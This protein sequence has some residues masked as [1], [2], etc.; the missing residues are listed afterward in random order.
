M[1][2]AKKL[3]FRISL[4]MSRSKKGKSLAVNLTACSLCCCS[5]SSTPARLGQA[6][7]CICGVR[8][9][10]VGF[11]R[12]SGAILLAQLAGNH[13][14]R[15][16]APLH[17]STTLCR[18]LGWRSVTR[19]FTGPLGALFLLRAALSHDVCKSSERMGRNQ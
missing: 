15:E 16:D 18:H 6:S 3:P 5:S 9:F 14:R 8:P 12:N 2:F 11:A 7:S 17:T 4:S 10:S 13:A 19:T 1:S